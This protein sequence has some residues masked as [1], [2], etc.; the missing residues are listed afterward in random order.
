MD[1]RLEIFTLG[2]VRILRDGQ[3]VGG[4]AS[5]KAESLLIYLA[6]TRQPQPREVLADLLWDERSQSQALAN[7]RVVLT[8]LRQALGESVI[9]TRD[10]VGLNPKIP[11]WL[12]AAEIET[13]LEG[14]RAKGGL[15]PE[16]VPQIVQALEL[17]RGY[18]LAGFTVFDCRGYEDW[19]TRERE[20]LRHLAVDGFSELVTYE[21][22]QRDYPAGKGHVAR[23]LELDPL[24]ES[25]HRQ[26]MLL[27]ANSGQRSA[28]LT[29]YETCH[30]LL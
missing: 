8:S 27:L 3:P 10:Q 19:V 24:N 30:R 16:T 28:A 21:L 13:C 18:F 11:V 22:A 23:L 12:D 5:R 29:Q 7:L 25:A 6:S 17:Y 26:M 4:F 15:K 14:L 9:I 1:A 2:G 20:H